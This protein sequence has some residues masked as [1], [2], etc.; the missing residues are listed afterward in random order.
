MFEIERIDAFRSISHFEQFLIWIEKEK[1]Y[2]TVIEIKSFHNGYSYEKWF[3]WKLNGQIWKLVYPDPGY[4]SGFWRKVS[5]FERVIAWATY[6]L[7]RSE[8]HYHY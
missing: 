7:L 1:Q 2:G 6:C 4:F 8:K 3:K 5:L